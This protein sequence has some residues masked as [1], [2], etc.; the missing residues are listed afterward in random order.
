MFLEDECNNLVTRNPQTFKITMKD[1]RTIIGPRNVTMHQHALQIMPRSTPS[2]PANP[3]QPQTTGNYFFNKIPSTLPA[4]PVATVNTVY[5][6]AP[7]QATTSRIEEVNK[8]EEAV[9]SLEDQIQALTMM[10]SDS[11]RQFEEIEASI[12]K[13]DK[14][15]NDYNR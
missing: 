7:S 1:G 5:V 14:K 8:D 6:T 11:K 3:V 2:Q 10:A 15:K 4:I 13:L 9:E 12:F